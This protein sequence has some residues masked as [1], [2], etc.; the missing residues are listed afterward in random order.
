MPNTIVINGATQETRVAVLEGGVIRDFFLERRHSRS[1][2]GN[3]YKGRVHRV[4]PGM[5]AAFVDIGLEKAAFL[6]VS[7]VFS[8]HASFDGEDA[9]DAGDGDKGDGGRSRRR[10]PPP[11]EEQIKQGQELLVQITKE[12]I[13]TKGARVTCHISLPG[14]HLVFMP[15]VEHLGISRQIRSDRE[16]KRLRKVAQEMRPKG[17]GFIVRTAS[18]GVPSELLRRD[19]KILIDTWNDIHAK[20]EKSKA[21]KLL[22][23]DLDV[24]L[25]ATRDL[26]TEDIDDL[27]VDTR[28][29]Y[30]R[31]MDFVERVMPGFGRRVKL[32]VG[33]EPIF[34][35]YGI[36][37]ELQAALTRRADLPNGGYLI[38]EKT[39]ALTS[40]DVNTGRFVGDGN[41]LED[42]IVQTNIEAAREIPYQLKLRG[43]GGLIIIDFID[44]DDPKNRARVEKTFQEAL[45][46]DKGRVKFGRI[47]EFG[48]ME[49]T[50]K[51]TGERLVQT[52]SR[53]C[54]ACG[55]TGIVSTPETVAYEILR[56]LRRKLGLIDD[57]DVRVTVNPEVGNVLRGHEAAAVRELELRYNKKVVL[58]NDRGRRVDK[59]DIVGAS[60]QQAVAG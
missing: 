41:S 25:K 32:Y 27:V 3:V 56:D 60:P 53:E 19:M 2:V 14:R 54:T 4:L 20:A 15:T 11:I 43:I 26:A 36:E 18:E 22:Y 10:N 45:S 9:D 51:R 16:R 39:E 48:I 35:A 57:H 37:A 59:Y 50:R 40:I 24:V 34:D 12:P 8:D 28:E 6:Y 5:Q 55:G 58:K 31:I 52:L 42:T 21:P 7:D 30:E 33:S 17:G 1:L 47:S 49:M 44:M 23:E 38:I 46:G 29:E 13:G